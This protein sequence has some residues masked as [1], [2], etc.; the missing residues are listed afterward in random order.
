MARGKVEGAKCMELVA[1]MVLLGAHS[2]K[3]MEL[4]A[5]KVEG[6]SCQ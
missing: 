4:V 5:D 1:D 3:C 2:K 6:A